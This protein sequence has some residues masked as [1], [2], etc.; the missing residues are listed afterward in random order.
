M[1]SNSV[2]TVNDN[3]WG[4]VNDLL[5]ETQTSRNFH[6][7][8]HFIFFCIKIM[9]QPTSDFRREIIPLVGYAIKDLAL[10]NFI[11]CQKLKIGT[12]VLFSE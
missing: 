8:E 2:L 7:I 12:K 9:D 1:L 10:H 5:F 6:N 11:S 3:A 4:H